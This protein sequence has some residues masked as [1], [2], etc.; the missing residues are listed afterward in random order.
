MHDDELWQVF[1]E[2]GEPVV[3]KG[4]ID[5][6]FDEDNTLVKANAHVWLWKRTDEGVMLLLQKRALTKKASP[7]M[8][9][10]SAAGHVN[11]DETPAQ[12][13][14]RE[15][16]EE[17]GLDLLKKDLFFIHAVRSIRNLQSL[18]YVYVYELHGGEQFSF[19]DGEVELVKWIEL[20]RFQ[21]MTQEAASHQL[22]DQGR[23]YFDPLIETI[24][25][26]AV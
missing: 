20:D 19:D 5:R 2:N 4:V 6:D 10:V 24:K 17:I 7:G 25:R 14:M 16:K 3:G 22:I 12:A 1:A 26:L 21:Q 18:A 9:H 11:L 8:Y 15:T 23:S 13:A